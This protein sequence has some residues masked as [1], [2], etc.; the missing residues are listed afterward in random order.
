LAAFLQKPGLPAG[1]A[2]D[3]RLEDFHLPVLQGKD[4]SQGF[5]THF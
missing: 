4:G 1:A 3:G 2:A 5:P